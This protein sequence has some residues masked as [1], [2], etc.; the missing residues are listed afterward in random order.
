MVTSEYSMD[1]NRYNEIFYSN[2]FVKES[3]KYYKI[4]RKK[5]AEILAMF[6]KHTEGRILDIGC[7]DGFITEIIGR[8]T[9][10]RM[11]GIDISGN[12]LE[13]SKKRGVECSVVNIDKERLPFPE[14]Y[15]DAVFCGDIIEH[16]YDTE[17]LL[18]NVHT[19]MKKGGYLIATVPNI[20][21]WYNRGFLLLGMMPTWIESSSKTFTGN[22]MIKKGVGHIHAFTKKSLVDLLKLKGFKIEKEKGCPIMGDGTRAR[23]KEAIWNYVDSFFA[24]KTSLASTIIVKAKK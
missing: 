21:S 10:A 1:T 3:D 2:I 6:D 18:E 19:V 17:G 14:D 9:G 11:F 4:Q 23:R 22:P 8:K 7:G 24:K 16:V 12:A 20:A 5:I 15:F 13:I